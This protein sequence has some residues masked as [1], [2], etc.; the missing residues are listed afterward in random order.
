M[1]LKFYENN[2]DDHMP[3]TCG[4]WFE[5]PMLTAKIFLLRS[6]FNFSCKKFC[7]VFLLKNFVKAN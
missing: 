6:F 3:I 2:A 4:T 5:N 1:V 7:K